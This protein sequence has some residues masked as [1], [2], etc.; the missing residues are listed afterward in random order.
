MKFINKLDERRWAGHVM[1][2]EASE[3][4]KSFVLEQEEVEIE[5]EADQS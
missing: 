5:E 1:W 3:P 2:M 4:A